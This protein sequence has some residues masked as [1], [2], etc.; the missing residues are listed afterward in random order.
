MREARV[1]TNFNDMKRM[2]FIRVAVF[3]FMHTFSLSAQNGWLPPAEAIVVLQN[4]YD[5]LNEPPVPVPRNGI[6]PE[7]QTIDQIRESVLGCSK[8]TLGAVKENFLKETLLRIK[9]G[10]D[11]GDAVN[12]ARTTMIIGASG[13][14]QAILMA[15]QQAYDW[16]LTILGG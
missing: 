16:M 15:I 11:T 7:Q 10:M 13:G 14:N 12:E 9:Q 3:A 4:K 2:N 6:T 5:Q 8:C 1:I